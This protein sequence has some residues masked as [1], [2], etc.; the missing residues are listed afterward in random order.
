MSGRKISLE[1]GDYTQKKGIFI[2]AEEGW[3]IRK[4]ILGRGEHLVHI[5]LEA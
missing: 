1:T 2:D 5:M 4:S 3:K